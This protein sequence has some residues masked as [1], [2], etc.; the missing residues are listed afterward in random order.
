MAGVTPATVSTVA[1][2][3][4]APSARNGNTTPHSATAFSTGGS[5]HDVF[6]QDA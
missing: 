6:H 5:S 3:M 2:D 1:D 4:G